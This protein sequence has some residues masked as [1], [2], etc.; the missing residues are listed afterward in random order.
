MRY[1][2]STQ[3]HRKEASSLIPCHPIP[4]EHYYH[5]PTLSDISN[6]RSRAILTFY[7][8]APHT[9]LTLFPY[10]LPYMNSYKTWPSVWKRATLILYIQGSAIWIFQTNYLELSRTHLKWCYNVFMHKMRAIKLLRCVRIN[11][12]CL[13]FRL[14]S[15]SVS[16]ILINS[17]NKHN[18]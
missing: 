13:S 17:L 5:T 14:W 7:D 6:G 8:T 9:T 4:S 10:I 16:L 1:S 3:L 11:K 12:T 15:R 18:D 2:I